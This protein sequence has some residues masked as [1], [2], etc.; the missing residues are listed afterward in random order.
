M[1]VTPSIN[2][3]VKFIFSLTYNHYYSRLE[4]KHKYVKT[5]YLSVSGLILLTMTL[6]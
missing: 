6:V 3:L 4:L 2:S 1:M 5:L